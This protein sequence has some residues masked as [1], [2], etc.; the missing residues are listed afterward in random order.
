S[1]KFDP[2]DENDGVSCTLPIGILPQAEGWWFEWLVPGLLGDKIALLLRSL[3]RS[4]RRDIQPI[5]DTAQSC[6]DKIGKPEKPLCEALGDAVFKI[7]G[8]KI[9]A[10]AW[11]PEELPAYLKMNFV[12]VDAKGKTVARGRDLQELKGRF[13]VEAKKQ[14]V[15]TPKSRHERSGITTWDFGD[16]PERVDLSE[17]H[18]TVWGFPALRDDGDS[19]SICVYDTPEKAASESRHGLRRLFQLSLGGHAAHIRKSLPISQGSGLV[20][21]SIGG[22]IETLRDDILLSAIDHVCIGS[23]GLARTAAAFHERYE[24]CRSELYKAAYDLGQKVDSVL[25]DYAR[26]AKML[27]ASVPEVMKAAVEDMKKQLGMLVYSGFIRQ[28]PYAQVFEIPRYIVAMAM[29]MQKL[30]EGP[31]KDSDRMGMIDVW[32]NRYMDLTKKLKGAAKSE[33][34]ETLRWMIEEYR[35]NIFAQKLGTPEPV[36]EKRLASQLDKAK[37]AMS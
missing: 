21:G 23:A 6:L 10:D 5:N 31:K 26:A 15:R 13:T 24:K 22:S 2:G 7:L 16:L 35:V 12:V 33:E 11:R 3:P 34:L 27:E 8:I 28:T 20:Y 14:F 30:R 29:R 36:S 37:L 32:W 4:V 17:G 18:G 9:D 1:Y 19:V 25:A